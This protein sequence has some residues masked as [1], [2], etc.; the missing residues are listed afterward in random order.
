MLS[1]M[2]KSMF[3]AAGISGQQTNHSLRA[4]GASKMFAKGV[5][6]M[7]VQGRT[8]HRSLEALRVHERPTTSQ[9][10]AVSSVLCSTTKEASFSAE[11]ESIERNESV[12]DERI[13]AASSDPSDGVSSHASTSSCHR[14]SSHASYSTDH[15]DRSSAAASSERGSVAASS[16]RGSV[17]ESSERGSTASSDHVG[18]ASF[19]FNFYLK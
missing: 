15:S 16:E 5:P 2:V 7:L 8:G 1:G 13:A 18:P 17:A 4:T 12:E 11:V 10:K 19:V 3:A 6:E 9:L 14:V